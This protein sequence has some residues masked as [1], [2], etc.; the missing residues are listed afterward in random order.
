[1][2]RF[3][4]ILPV[5]FLSCAAEAECICACVNGQ[6]QTLCSSTLDIRPICAPQICPIV[7]PSIQP[8]APPT[9]PPLGTSQCELK[10]VLNPVTKQYE[11]KR[12][13]Q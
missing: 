6:V 7:P 10:Q 1:M 9:I 4:F 13:C 5:L 2:K 3:L 12:I 8:I 11:W